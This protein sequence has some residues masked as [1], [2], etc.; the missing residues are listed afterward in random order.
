M[1]GGTPLQFLVGIQV[2][3]NEEK[4]ESNGITWFRHIN[5]GSD[6]GDVPVVFG[7]K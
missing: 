1:D 5:Q 3:G 7:T 6:M 4:S 2:K